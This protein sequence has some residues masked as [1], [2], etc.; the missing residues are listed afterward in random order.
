ML[1]QLLDKKLSEFQWLYSTLGLLLSSIAL[2]ME[3]ST[4]F[5]GGVL[6]LGV[7]GVLF[8][9]TIGKVFKENF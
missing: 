5:Y 8:L 1:H 4:L 7:G 2:L 3:S 6:L 9:V